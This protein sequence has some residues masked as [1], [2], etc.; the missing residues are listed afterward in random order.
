MYC[1]PGINTNIFVI[2]RDLNIP[3]V[4]G[5][6]IRMFLPPRRKGAKFEGER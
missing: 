2:A 4:E 3:E 6:R 5:S 1:Y